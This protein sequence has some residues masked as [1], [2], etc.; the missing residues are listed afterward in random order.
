MSAATPTR[1]SGQ[2]SR[3]DLACTAAASAYQKQFGADL[4]RRVVDEGEPF[5][6]VSVQGSGER[7]GAADS[8][9]GEPV[10]GAADRGSG[11][12]ATG[13]AD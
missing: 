10:A 1:P 3:K 4:R 6:G 5:A 9:S 11:E 12:S 2:R 7:A 8:G 13:A